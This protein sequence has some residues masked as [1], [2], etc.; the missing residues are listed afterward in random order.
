MIAKT[1]MKKNSFPKTIIDKTIK[2]YLDSK[3]ETSISENI[4]K[5]TPRY[6]KLPFTGRYSSFTQIKL[7]K[8]I[9]KYCKGIAIKLVFNPFKIGS[10][11]TLKDSIPDALKSN[12]VYK[13]SCAGCNAC[14]IGET[15]R[16]LATRTK[17]HLHTDKSSYVYKHLLSSDDCRSKCDN[18]CFKILDSAP[19]RYQLM[20]KEGMYI[21]WQKPSLNKQ[22][23]CFSM[24]IT[25]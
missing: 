22:V 10:M 18:L 15:T 7:N 17:E 21:A 13:F 23:K 14:Y 25:I 8:I 16:H 19:S 24:S 2:S 6:Y 20:I 9:N 5:I 4:E 3:L 1:L 12:V 11:F